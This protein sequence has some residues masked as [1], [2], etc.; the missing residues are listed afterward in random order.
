MRHNHEERGPQKVVN[1]NIEHKSDSKYLKIFLRYVIIALSIV[2]A[3]YFLIPGENSMEYI[4]AFGLLAALLG[5]L[6]AVASDRSCDFFDAGTPV[7]AGFASSHTKAA[8]DALQFVGLYAALFV[9]KKSL[10]SLLI[11]VGVFVVFIIFGVASY[12][13]A[14]KI[15]KKKNQERI[16][17]ATKQII[18][19]ITA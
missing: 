3:M 17:N 2:A 16:E 6:L 5:F 19:N 8:G 18:E 9:D 4:N 10:L 7:Q 15:E 13:Q 1:I 11:L 12:I 14:R